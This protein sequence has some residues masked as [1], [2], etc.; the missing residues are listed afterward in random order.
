MPNPTPQVLAASSGPWA[1]V[2][3]GTVASATAGSAV[4]V[5]GGTS[6]PASF[7]SPYQP[8]AGDLVSVIRQDSSW[9]ILG[10]IAGAGSSLVTNGSFE[11]SE[12]GT[13]PVGWTLYDI[14]SGS[15][16]SVTD[17]VAV[18][19]G[20]SALVTATTAT[21]AQSYL[22]S[23]AIPVT[24]GDV[25]T[26][27]AYAGASLGD[28]PPVAVD[29]A[30]YVLWFAN[31][32]DLYPTTVGPDTFVAD[33]TDIVPAPPWTPLSG[34]VTSTIDG[35]MRVALRSTVNDTTGVVWDFV[36]ARR[37]EA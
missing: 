19:G 22:Y 32:T 10:R 2:R 17:A 21:T 35:W 37:N 16:A 18:D 15:T 25:L 14:A 31:P 29:A 24:T 8:A 9:Q 28:N 33:A 13:S 1:Q 23:E 34:E 3:T 12:V 30:L 5:V 6:F 20:Q 27:S 11:Q 4:V 26:V 7:I 36:T